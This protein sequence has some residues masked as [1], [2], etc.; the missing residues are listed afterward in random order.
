MSTQVVLDGR[1]IRYNLSM[2]ETQLKLHFTPVHPLNFPYREILEE[3]EHPSARWAH[4]KR[5]VS[6]FVDVEDQLCVLVTFKL[7][8]A[9]GNMDFTRCYSARVAPREMYKNPLAAF[10]DRL[11]VADQ[12]EEQF[13]AKL[14][15][16]YGNAQEGK[17]V[18]WHAF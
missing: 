3:S 11:A 14:G 9:L 5:V 12:C 2:N 15:Q 17:P 10:P 16:F 4:V 1:R 7:A 18:H 8:D 6:L 13:A